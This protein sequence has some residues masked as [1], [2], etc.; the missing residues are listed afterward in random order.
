MDMRNLDE[1]T[2]GWL[3]AKKSGPNKGQRLESS[4]FELD[5]LTLLVEIQ[6]ERGD[7]IPAGLD[8]MDV[9]GTYR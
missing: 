3:Y 5:V 6:E 2:S 1:L 9:Y 8:V 7:L 4:H